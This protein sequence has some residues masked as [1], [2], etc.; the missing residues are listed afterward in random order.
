MI[1]K[2]IYLKLNLIH[3]QSTKILSNKQPAQTILI[4]SNLQQEIKV[5]KHFIII[6]QQILKP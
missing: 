1:S 3:K 4:K 6:L 2:Y 5:Q